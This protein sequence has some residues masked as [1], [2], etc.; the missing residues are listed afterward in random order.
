MDLKGAIVELK[1]FQNF[2]ASKKPATR[3]GDQYL[4]A[5]S[6]VLAE[7]ERL[8]KTIPPSNRVELQKAFTE[9]RDYCDHN[10]GGKG[11]S[12]LANWIHLV[13]AE[14]KRL[15]HLCLCSSCATDRPGGP[16]P[17]LICRECAR[18]EIEKAAAEAARQLMRGGSVI[19]KAKP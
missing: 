17:A 10:H 5:S 8:L 16:N 15:Q 4:Q 2:A 6:I 7:V 13:L 9:L 14:V 3:A 19:E 18:E 12:Y 11:G 1:K